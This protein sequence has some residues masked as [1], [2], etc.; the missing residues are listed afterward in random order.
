[1]HIHGLYTYCL[2]LNK[3]IFFIVQ[4]GAQW[5]FN[6]QNIVHKIVFMCMHIRSSRVYIVYFILKMFLYTSE[7]KGC[8]K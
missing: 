3:V 4:N 1:M 2:I 5:Y 6:P 7:I 8:A